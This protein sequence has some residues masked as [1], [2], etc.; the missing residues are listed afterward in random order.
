VALAAH[1]VSRADDELFAYGL[2]R[3]LVGIQSG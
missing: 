1:L 3:L 2:D